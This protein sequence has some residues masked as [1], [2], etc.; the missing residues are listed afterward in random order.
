MVRFRSYRWKL[1][2]ALVALGMSAIA[3]TGWLASTGA[4][5]ALREAN[6]NRLTAVRETKRRQVE[7]YF[8]D[9][10]NH[11]LAL[12]SD[13]SSV[14]ALEEF[15]DSWNRLP[16]TPEGSHSDVA[17]RRFYA[18]EVA[19]RLPEEMASEKLL[20][21]WYPRDG[22]RRTLQSWFLSAN[23]HPVGAKDLLLEPTGSGE[24]GSVHARYHPTLHR[25]QAAFGFY[26]VLLVEAREARVLYSVM[27]EIDIGARLDQEPYAQT[28]LAMVYRRAM[29]LNDPDH[30]VLEDYAPYVASYLAPAAFAAAPVW[31]AGQ[32]IGVLAIQVSIAEVNRVM[33]G[34]RHWLEEG[35]G[36]TGQAYLVGP[37]GKLRSD[38]REEIEQPEKFYG[39]LVASG[40]DADTL[41]KIRSARTVVLNLPSG[42]EVTALMRTA[43]TASGEG[44]SLRGRPVLRSYGPVAVE[45]LRWFLVAEIETEEV[46]RPLRAL[47][48][49]I[50]LAG[51]GVAVVLFCAAWWLAG[52][53]T[54]P[55]RAL[56]AATARFGEA[57]FGYRVPRHSEDEIGNLAE[58]F[59]KMAVSLQRTTVSRNDLDQANRELRAKQEELERLAARLIEAQ[60][61]ERRRL[62]RELH[63][64]ITQRVAALSIEAGRLRGSYEDE[65]E[66]RAGLQRV[67]EAL[68]QLS[69]D[70]HGLSRRLHPS[71]LEDLGLEAALEAECRGFF[72]R[73]GPPVEFSAASGVDGLRPDGKLALYRITQASLRNVERHAGAS[74][75]SVRLWRQDGWAVIEISDNGRGFDRGNPQWRPGVGLA[76]MEE[77]ARLLGGELRVVSTPGKGT[78]VVARIPLENS[79]A[80]HES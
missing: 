54:K 11:V 58:S 40:T 72:E 68:M 25:Y 2:V 49:R 57:D 67:Q 77:R 14:R 66:M 36:Q 10:R 53:V 23:P 33:T 59:N 69:S 8:R 13:E 41:R 24:F 37:D 73:G 42:A 78:T 27:K 60:E 80:G 39:E 51:L 29:Q 19:P 17:L 12:S 61:E 76:S 52:S 32:K 30:A 74:D 26:D 46:N 48:L 6:F 75:V 20:Q 56:A 35:M 70:I 22:R 3:M 43:G 38:L 50:G 55:V 64:D 63:D 45:G 9:L 18:A 21:D 65:E 7:D 1:Q 16:A 62:G 4:A 34:G 47:V 44:R 28:G 15:R 71:V 5:V 79:A 31:R